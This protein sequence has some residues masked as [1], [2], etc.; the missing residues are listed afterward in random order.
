MMKRISIVALSVAVVMTLVTM[1][2]VHAQ[3]PAAGHDMSNM[4]MPMP[5]AKPAAKT[6]AKASVQPAA[7]PEIF[8]PTMK[9]GQLCS[10][11]TGDAL[12]L[13]GD[14]YDQWVASARRYNKAVD[15]AT[16]QLQADVKGML[17]AQQNAEL[18]RWFEQGLNVQMND[19]LSQ[20]SGTKTASG[21]K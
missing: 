1:A 6:T 20:S 14:K 2:A 10:H 11:G 19:L 16:L 8:C 9:T 7:V 3:Q 15:V 13:T 12:K 17:T 4:K 21:T 18:K 5:A